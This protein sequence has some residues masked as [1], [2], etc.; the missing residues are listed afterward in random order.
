MAMQ[1]RRSVEVEAARARARSRLGNEHAKAGSA[2]CGLAHISPQPSISDVT[3]RDRSSIE[4]T[5]LRA[6]AEVVR[7]GVVSRKAMQ[8]VAIAR[9]RAAGIEPD[10][11]PTSSTTFGMQRAWLDTETSRI[12]DEQT[13]TAAA[14]DW[15]SDV[16]SMAAISH[17]TSGMAN[18]KTAR[19]VVPMPMLPAQL[20]TMCACYDGCVQE[21]RI[22]R[23]RAALR[24]QSAAR[25]GQSPP[26]PPSLDSRLP[27]SMCSSAFR[28]IRCDRLEAGV[29]QTESHTHWQHGVNPDSV[30]LAALDQAEPVAAGLQMAQ[31][32]KSSTRLPSSRHV[33]TRSPTSGTMCRASAQGGSRIQSRILSARASFGLRKSN[34]SRAAGGSTPISTGGDT[35]LGS[36]SSSDADDPVREEEYLASESSESGLPV[37]SCSACEWGSGSDTHV[38]SHGDCPE[39]CSSNSA[40]AESQR[41]N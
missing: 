38:Q 21:Q 22:A 13:S 25:S 17:C 29:V 37:P 11:K 39:C 6:A 5:Y 15:L 19:E 1:E 32:R 14:V 30:D 20:L 12:D 10:V 18:H 28:G 35:P 27:K 33:P 24:D 34:N 3:L 9:Q 16:I 26:A 41:L 8:V 7:N 4:N 40:L 36:G 2:I 23:A 31:S